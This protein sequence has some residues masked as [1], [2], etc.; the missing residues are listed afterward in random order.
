MKVEM[1]GTQKVVCHFCSAT[2]IFCRFTRPI[3]QVRDPFKVTTANVSGVRIFR[4]FTVLLLTSEENMPGV[5]VVG[6]AEDH[7]AVYRGSVCVEGV[8]PAQ[9]HIPRSE[10][11]TCV[12]DSLGCVS[13]LIGCHSCDLWR[14]A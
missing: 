14:G 6:L 4:I 1:F 11:D 2:L 5:T 9:H 7:V 10:G 3:R 12:H 8:R 13:T